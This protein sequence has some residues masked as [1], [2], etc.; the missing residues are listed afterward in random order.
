[1]SLCYDELSYLYT[2]LEFD[3]EFCMYYTDKL[4]IDK[5]AVS[6]TDAGRKACKHSK[7][8]KIIL[9]TH[10]FDTKSYPSS[11]DVFKIIYSFDDEKMDSMYHQKELIITKWGIW[12][13]SSSEK[14]I[15]PRNNYGKYLHTTINDMFAALYHITEKGRC[16]HLN[17][18]QKSMIKSTIKSIVYFMKHEL[19]IDYN[20]VFTPWEH[21]HSKYKI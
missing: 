15:I 12:K 7:P 4:Y 1:M 11:E 8:Y 10:P 14:R 6:F 20:I 18:A 2:L 16:D 3:H 19:D 13:L 5:D 21:I 17:S 9:H